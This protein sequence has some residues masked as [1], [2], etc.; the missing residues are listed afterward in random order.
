[1]EISYSDQEHAGD[2]RTRAYAQYRV[3]EAFRSVA[4]EVRR[5]DVSIGRARGPADVSGRVACTVVA[6]LRDG[7]HIEVTA[8]GDWPY[9]AIQDAAVRARQR[10]DET[11]TSC[12]R[13]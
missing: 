2:G 4:S 5:I 9:A 7:Q 1:M 10:L 12:P 13:P 8:G 11:V 3:F 6:H